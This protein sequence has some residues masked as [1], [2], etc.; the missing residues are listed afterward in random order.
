MTIITVILQSLLHLYKDFRNKFVTN[1]KKGLTLGGNDDT[2]AHVR[3][4]RRY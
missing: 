3:F 4:K 1:F 2:I